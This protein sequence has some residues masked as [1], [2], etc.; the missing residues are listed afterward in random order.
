MDC[1]S[2]L[3]VLLASYRIELLNNEMMRTTTQ[4][5]RAGVNNDCSQLHRLLASH[6]HDLSNAQET[7]HRPGVRTP[8][9]FSAFCNF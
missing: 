2:I 5:G 7:E 3:I 6:S 9:S 1:I 4:S 8:P